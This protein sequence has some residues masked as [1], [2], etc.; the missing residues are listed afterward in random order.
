M[1]TVPIPTDTTS[2]TYKIPIIDDDLFEI[3]ETF[4]VQI[5]DTSLHRQI[6]RTQPFTTTVTMYDDE[7]RESFV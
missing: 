5:V 6:K 1:H 2:F 4:K 3:D 7:E